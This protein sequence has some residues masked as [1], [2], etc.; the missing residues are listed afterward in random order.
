MSLALYNTLTRCKE[1]FTPRQPG[2]VTM[3]CCGV[4]VYDDCHLGHARSYIG[5]DVVRRYLQWHGYQ[6][7]YVQN[8]TAIDDKI[9]NRAKAEDC[10]MEQIAD[11]YIDAYFRDM[12]RLNILDAD[13]YPRVTGHI[14]EIQQFIQSLEEKGYAY[15]VGGDVYYN[16]RKCA[17]YGKL[18]GRQ[19]EQMP[20]GAGGQVD[21]DDPDL[22]KR[23]PADFALWK[24]AKLGEPA[25]PS[26]WG[27]G[28]PG[29]HIECSAMIKTRLGETIDIHGGGA[30]LIFPHHENEIAQSEVLTGQPLAH[31]W[32]HNGMVM[33]NGE[34]MSK[35]LGNFITIHDLLE[36]YW[37]DYPQPVDPMAI[38]LFVLQAHY[39]KPLDFT[40]AAITAAEKSWQTLK[41][42][43]T[44]DLQS[45][46]FLSQMPIPG[47][48]DAESIHRFQ[49][50]MDD[51]LNTAA[52]LAVL[53]ELAKSIKRECNLRKYQLEQKL[54]DLQLQVTL[55]TLIQLSEVLGLQA[56]KESKTVTE[57]DI[58][59]VEALLK[60]RQQARQEK[61]YAEG[62]RIRA[63]LQKAGITLI[64][65]PDGQT[66]WLRA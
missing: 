36:G 64:D 8:F 15:S 45:L 52:G 7:Y 19:L 21:P 59:W 17:G 42:A 53:F 3:Y 12:R 49:I 22:K 27:L 51:D 25:W 37:S 24:A 31:Y 41:E 23:D 48:L 47:E 29:W 62:D 55:Q 43:L 28:R 9:L 20:T 61:R 4:T 13:E 44:I 18:S 33:V 46:S 63:Q 32:L 34:K 6:V 39:R 11:R 10:S 60:Q 54:S 40:K 65:Q 35:S 58:H 30:D 56:S 14:P 2:R 16:V 26:P 66:R 38:R 5:W 57:L 1:P 50:A